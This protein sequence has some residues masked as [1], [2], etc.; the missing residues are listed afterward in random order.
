M[1]IICPIHGEF[2]QTP[3][4]HLK[5]CGCPKCK[6]SRLENKIK[7]FLERN[8]IIYIYQYF[9]LFLRNG[10]T[11]QSLD[12]YLPD[13]NIAIECQGMQHFKAVELFGGEEQLKKQKELDYNK[14]KLCEDNNIKVLYYSN[15]KYRTDDVISKL[16]ILKEK[17]YE[18]K[19]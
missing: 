16:S 13:Y 6:S 2:W 7:L 18:N 11:H 17:I 15:Y 19:V 14:K 5:G 4:L 12:F 1:C 9:P 10:R 3:H 8:N